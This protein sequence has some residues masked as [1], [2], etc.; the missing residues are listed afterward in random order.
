MSSIKAC[1]YLNFSPKSTILLKWCSSNTDI[2]YHSVISSG[3][4]KPGT[5]IFQWKWSSFSSLS[6]SFYVSTNMVSFGFNDKSW[7]HR[8]TWKEVELEFILERAGLHCRFYCLTII[9]GASKAQISPWFDARIK[10]SRLQSSRD[11]VCNRFWMFSFLYQGR[12]SVNA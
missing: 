5:V 12:K 8:A 4:W 2:L 10:N 11:Q 3:H 7:N 6:F 9:P 1:Y